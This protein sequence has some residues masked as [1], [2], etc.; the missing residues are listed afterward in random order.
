[1]FLYSTYIHVLR[2]ECIAKLNIA[3]SGLMLNLNYSLKSLK[4][5]LKKKKKA[6]KKEKKMNFMMSNHT[7]EV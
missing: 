1:M 5:D 6:S 7:E 4:F 2:H 3:Y